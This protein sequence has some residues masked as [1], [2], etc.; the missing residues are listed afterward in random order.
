MYAVML[1][2]DSQVDG[3]TRHHVMILHKR[4]CGSKIFETHSAITSG[5][6]KSNV[7]IRHERDVR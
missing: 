7:I 1:V 4:S 2:G 5:L 3:R 6:R